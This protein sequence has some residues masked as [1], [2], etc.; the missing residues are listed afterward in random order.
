MTADVCREPYSF[1]RCMSFAWHDIRRVIRAYF[2]GVRRTDLVKD[3]EFY[4]RKEYGKRERCSWGKNGFYLRH[5]IKCI[6]LEIKHG[7]F[8]QGK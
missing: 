3:G 1:R 8:D 4:K 7:V 2:I 6:I 5:E